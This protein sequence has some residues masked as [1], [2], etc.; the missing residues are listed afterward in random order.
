M[1]ALGQCGIKTNIQLHASE[2]WFAPPPEGILFGR[3]FDLGEFAW[4]TGV[5]P[6]CDLYLSSEVGG[7]MNQ[8]WKSIQDEQIRNFP[9]SGWWGQNNTGFADSDYD[10]A[11]N[12]AL[13]SL[14]GQPQYETGHREAQRIFAE[15]LPVA[16]LFLRMKSAATRPDFCNFI[17]DPTSSSEFWNIENFDYGPG[18]EE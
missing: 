2:E 17:M 16:P 8:T 15:Q 6:P 7:P 18:C 4:L 5:D 9:N 11:C 14:I 13:N 1:Q 12:T 3:R 10:A